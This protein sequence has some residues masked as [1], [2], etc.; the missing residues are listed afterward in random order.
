LGWRFFPAL[1]RFPDSLRGRW[2]IRRHDDVHAVI[3]G[4]TCGPLP[5]L[6]GRA[7]LPERAGYLGYVSAERMEG[8]KGP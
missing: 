8:R 5:F 1:Y 7:K 4:A 6:N 2:V 3:S